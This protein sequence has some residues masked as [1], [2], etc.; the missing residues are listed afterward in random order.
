MKK[1]S[2]LAA[3]AALAFSGAA[4]A[5][6]PGASNIGHASKARVFP[7]QTVAAVLYDQNDNDSGIGITSQNFEA[8]FDIYD[9]Q[10]ADDFTVPSTETWKVTEV[11]V[12]GVYYNGAGPAASQH[13]TFY[14]NKGG[15]PN[16][17]KVVADFPAVMG[18]DNGFGSFVI[19]LP[20]AVKLKPGKYWVSVQVNMDFSAG[21]QWGW[22]GRTVQNGQM[23]AWQN[24]G[25][26][27]ATGC[28]SWNYESVCIPSG[29]GPDKMFALKGKAKP[30]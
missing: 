6:G 18:A 23:A 13:V 21:G 14:K 11:D 25:D 5:A 12:T 4:M 19:T 30:I 3:A 2:V 8:S 26:G 24:P 1:T 29:Q 20:S 10:G 17:A 7:S 27:F 16:S 22:E 9:N 15:L 28:T